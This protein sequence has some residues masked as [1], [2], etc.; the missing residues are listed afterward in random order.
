M[1][2]KKNIRHIRNIKNNSLTAMPLSP[3]GATSECPFGRRREAT[4]KRRDMIV[5]MAKLADK[6]SIKWVS[7]HDKEGRVPRG[8]DCATELEEEEEEV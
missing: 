1:K 4:Y 7:N 6:S 2:E 5:D 8:N 3:P